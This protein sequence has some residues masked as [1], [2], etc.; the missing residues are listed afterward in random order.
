M[1]TVVSRKS[2]Q[3]TNVA[4]KMHI[5]LGLTLKTQIEELG[6]QSLKKYLLTLISLHVMNLIVK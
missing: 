1:K 6:I 5:S 3:C 2:F 4:D